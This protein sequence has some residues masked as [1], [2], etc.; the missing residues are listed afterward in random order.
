MAK[1]SSILVALLLTFLF[2]PLGVFYSSVL[3]GVMLTGIGLLLLWPLSI[4]WGVG[5]TE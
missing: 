4:G 1:G 2:G 3:G 5:E